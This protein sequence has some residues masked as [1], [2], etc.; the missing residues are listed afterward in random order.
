MHRRTIGFREARIG[1]RAA[2]A[3]SGGEPYTHQP[4][5]DIRCVEGNT[6]EGEKGILRGCGAEKIKHLNQPSTTRQ[7][8]QTRAQRRAIGGQQAQ[9]QARF[10]AAD[11]VVHHD[12]AGD[13]ARR[14]HHNDNKDQAEIEIPSRRDIA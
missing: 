1:P 4:W 14:K 6:I 7:G 10:S 12:Q 9:Q 8:E 3:T 11:G 2:E 13:P 5:P